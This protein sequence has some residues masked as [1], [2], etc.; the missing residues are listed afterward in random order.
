RVIEQQ[1]FHHGLQNADEVVVAADVGKFVAEDRLELI[2]REAREAACR[3]K[4]S[5]AKPADDCGDLDTRR[6]QKEDGTSDP[7][8]CAKIV[9]ELLQIGGDRSS[10]HPQPMGSTEPNTKADEETED[11]RTP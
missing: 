11:P 10:I 4:H 6:I 9:K 8:A 2:G 3:Q 7:G 1:G 5:G